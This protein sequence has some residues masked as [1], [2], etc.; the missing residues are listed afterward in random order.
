MYPNEKETR[1]IL[2]WIVSKLPRCKLDE[3]EEDE[4][5]LDRRTNC[6]RDVAGWQNS[7]L[8]PERLSKVFLSWK[9]EKTLHVLPNEHVKELRGFQRLPMQ[10][11]PLALPWSGSQTRAGKL[12]EGFPSKY[13]KVTSLLEALVV[14]K[15][16][17]AMLLHFDQEEEREV[18]TTRTDL[19]PDVRVPNDATS[20]RER[21]CFAVHE[22]AMKDDK[23][24]ALQ[25]QSYFATALPDVPISLDGLP[26]ESAAVCGDK[27]SLREATDVDNDDAGGSMRPTCISQDEA[28]DEQ[29]MEQVQQ[30]VDDTKRRIAAMQKALHRERGELHQ[31]E[32]HNLET[33][34]TG[35][36]MQKQCTRQK[37]LVAMLS[38]APSNIAKLKSSCKLIAEKKDEVAQQ[39]KIARE[40]L[41]A[42]HAELEGQIRSR[43]AQRRQLI[44]E[45]KMFQREIQE[46]NGII[47]SKTETVQALAR[48]QERKTAKSDK[49]S[50]DG[51]MTRSMYIARIIDIVKQVHKQK[52]DI[53]K[54]LDD[55][56]RL[57]RSLGSASQKLKRTE[58]A[59]EAS[60]YHVACKSKS[61]G[62][63]S[64]KAEAYVD[65]YR[66]FAQVRDLFEKLIATVGDVGKNE[67][68][69]RDLR[70]WIV[71]LEARECSNHLDKVLADLGSVRGDNVAL[72][73]ELRAHTS[74]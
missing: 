63:S 49:N 34:R 70:N 13:V 35:Q 19:D 30:Q 25:P 73:H 29:I 62:A 68:R 15:R 36:E 23:C 60:I 9:R 46:M 55:I 43:K 33:Q 74:S 72:R 51:V 54:I 31:V 27:E 21:E 24:A 66:K 58:A 53:A 40:L 11:W 1:H 32:Q 38:D 37:Q 26:S 42:E 48:V 2:S 39:M 14:V 28:T 57:Q 20:A 4:Q 71:Q 18:E 64:T 45:I 12:F 16:D 10:T 41:L 61:K 5:V 47:R 44:R 67:N 7:V 52:Q 17:A 6:K 59:T 22:P 3:D 56:K 65:C 8:E 69:A 50:N